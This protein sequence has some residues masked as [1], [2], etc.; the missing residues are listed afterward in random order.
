[1][2]PQ[3]RARGML[4]QLKLPK[5][6]RSRAFRTRHGDDALVMEANTE[7]IVEG[8]NGKQPEEML[9]R[10]AVHSVSCKDGSS[11]WKSEQL[12]AELPSTGPRVSKVTEKATKDVTIRSLAGE[13]LNCDGLSTG[14]E[15]RTVKATPPV[16]P[17]G[18]DLLWVLSGEVYNLPPGAEP[19]G[20][21]MVTT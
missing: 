14:R 3:V 8:G 15:R 6:M 11:L 2:A 16:W 1:M 21:V 5:R 4:V 19:V 12:V 20:Q 7:V 13:V 17:S 18:A 10:R 9:C